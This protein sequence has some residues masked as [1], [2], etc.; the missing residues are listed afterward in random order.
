[1]VTG[2]GF[3]I[4]SVVLCCNPVIITVSL[5]IAGNIYYVP[6]VLYGIRYGGMADLEIVEN[7]E[8]GAHLLAAGVWSGAGRL[9]Q[10]TAVPGAVHH[11]QHLYFL[12]KGAT[13]P[14]WICMKKGFYT[15]R[16]PNMPEVGF[17]SE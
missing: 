8:E 6:D 4:C 1:M 14:D 15:N 2:T 11:P 5:T 16:D 17:I 3:L 10:H 7:P 9:P 13:R 12:F